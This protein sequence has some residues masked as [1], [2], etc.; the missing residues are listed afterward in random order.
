MR[1]LKFSDLTKA[2]F[3]SILI[4]WVCLVSA[5]A[6]PFEGYT[7][8]NPNNAT[9]T[10]LIDIN[11]TVVHT[12]VNARRGG[13]SVYLLENGHIMRPAQASNT[14][15]HGG[16]SAGLVHN[17]DW[18]GNLVWQFEYNSQTY[19]THHDIEPLSNGNV[20]L[21]AWEVKTAAEATAAGRSNA[22]EMWPDHIIEVEPAGASGGNIVWEW[23]AWDH[24]IQDYDST[25]ANYG[26]V[27]DHP[28]LID[29]NLGSSM[30][31]G[32]GDWLHINGIGYNPELDQIVI[33]S[34]VLDEFYVIDH[35]TTTAQAAGHTGG[36]SG[37]GG[38]ILYRWGNPANYR[39]PGSA[40][41]DV[42]HCALWIPDS[43]PGGG[44]IMAFNNGEGRHY[45]EIIEITPPIDSTGSYIYVPGAAYGPAAP[46]WSYS[47]GNGFFSQHLG[48]CQRLPNGNTLISEST[49]GYLFEVDYSGNVVWDYSYLYE[50][51]RSLRYAPDYPGLAALNQSCE[52]RN[53]PTIE[54][55]T[56]ENYPNPFNANTI[57][58]YEI[59]TAARVKLNVS[60]LLGQNVKTLVNEYKSPGS[61]QVVWDGTDNFKRKL[62]S[63]V[64][65]YSL[66]IGQQTVTKKMIMMK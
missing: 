17:T 63:G 46:A 16:A 28:E 10:Y 36:N 19:L 62:V 24:L 11:G 57:I 54:T 58:N 4:F 22:R 20:L 55:F 37:R 64:Y 9:T 23:H 12:W 27:S 2:L 15:L 1:T 8:F 48:S 26:V 51:A 18:N 61:Y 14:Y 47:A 34:H 60:N 7:L 66:K 30:G 43:L 49:S 39:A 44:N 40:Y 53:A 5:Q 50:I 31:P 13:Y 45:S 6:Q 42:V 35:S 3:S 33:S 52:N 41:F 59:N 25:K 21:I 29:V 38:D 32:G 56:M 65:L